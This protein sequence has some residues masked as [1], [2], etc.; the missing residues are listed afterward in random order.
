MS[1][2]DISIRRP[3]FAWML[4]SA[5]I[6][7][8]AISFM[9]MGVSQL[10]DV[11]FPVLSVS[12]I[13]DG[14]APEVIESE[15]VDPIEQRVVAV[16]GLKEVRSSVRQGSATVTLEFEINRDID[17]ALQEVQ[18]ALSQL[19]LPTGVDAPTIR[20]SN[21]EEDPIMFVGLSGKGRDLKELITFAELNLIDQFQVVPGVGEV[22]VGGFSTRNLRIWVNNQK[23]KQELLTV[24]DIV[25]A[26][27]QGHS[28]L[29]AGYLENDKNEIN[30]RTIGEGLSPEDIGNIWIK[31]R[32]GEIIREPVLQIKDVARVEDGLS[33]IRRMARIN[34]VDGLS[35]A[36][37]KQRGSNEV[38]VSRALRAKIEEIQ[39]TLPEG[40]SLGVNVD[41]TRFTEQLVN[42][43][44]EKLVAAGLLTALICFLFIGSWGS[45]INVLLSIPT[46]VL[47]TFIVLYFAGFTLNLFTLLALALAISIVVDDAIMMLENIVRHFKMG[48]GRKRAAS[49]GAR[50][51][52]LAAVAATVA[53]VAIFLPV[54]FMTGVIGKFFFQFGVTISAA[55]LLSL[56]EAVTLTP[57][58]CAQMLTRKDETNFVARTANRV[59]D[60]LADA[61]RQTLA[62]ALHWRWSVVLVSTAIFVGSLLLFPKIKKEFVPSTDQNFVFISFEVPTGSSLAATNHAAKRI[63][64]FLS[65]QDAVARYFISVG[66][67]GPSGQV[68]QG[69]GG[70]ALKP[71]SERK[72][73]HIEFMGMV[74]GHFKGDKNL[75]VNLR[76]LSTRGL[77]A[78]RSF[79]VSFNIR[80]PDYEVLKEKS[81]EIMKRLQATELVSDLDTDFRE[82]NPELQV[83]PNRRAAV[84]RGVDVENISRTISAA[85]GGIRQG[86]FTNDGRRY[87]I[88]IRLEPGDRQQ[89]SDLNRLMVRN[90]LQQLVPLNQ[91][92]EIRQASVVQSITRIDRLRAISIFANVPPGKSQ[93]AAL[94]SAENI[95]REVLPPGYSFHLEGAAQSFAESF[96]SLY[97]ALILGIVVA[98]M[99]LASQFNSFIHPIVVLLAL[100]FSISGALF[101]LWAFGES[102][103]LYSMIGILLL[104]GIAKKNSILLVEF[105]NH[106]R[107]HEGLAVREAQLKACPVRLRPI[108]MTSAATV[109]A[110]LPLAID[111]SPGF[112]T[113]IPMALAIIGGMTVSTLFT[114][115]VVPCAY[116]LFSGLERTGRE[117]EADHDLPHL[118]E[119][120][121]HGAS[122]VTSPSDGKPGGQALPRQIDPGTSQ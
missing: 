100:P 57:M 60:Q 74:R 76:D 17:A 64:E 89:E 106:V 79:P 61:Y 103:N 7:F 13:Y 75:R 87:D 93:G 37:R 25:A 10:P 116:E 108:L 24:L 29:A 3:V 114:L 78:G 44:I 92:A 115:Y 8:G 19:R 59:S 14:A 1:L 55:V 6:V 35:V 72:M 47:G 4:M 42:T 95:A 71:R 62:F 68:N 56:L 81:Q 21:P 5:L 31:S 33:D 51:I 86:Q 66:Q 54:I 112:E 32:G 82:G 122:S 101:A 9:R 46:S 40:I 67:G 58:R 83:I 99:V 39:K 16:E 109:A 110:A 97:F 48:K 73:S 107:E 45:V 34:G 26:I 94:A 117:H 65:Q 105:S 85:I 18:A 11:D 43:T 50:E 80:G 28:E 90:Y 30:V 22:Q 98:Y 52:M 91:V 84:Q 88:R 23:L 119:A 15:L 41:F 53:V 27:Q 36:I 111:S 113:R 102:L 70:I 20:K 120:N 49:E 104:M 69:F 2:A 77:T 12:V 121:G 118:I 96:Q 38:D 63:E